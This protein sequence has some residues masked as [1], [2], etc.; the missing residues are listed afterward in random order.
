MHPLLETTRRTAVR[1]ERVLPESA[2]YDFNKGIWVGPNGP[3]CNDP[4]NI[5][6]TKKEDIEVGEDQKGQ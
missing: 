4:E 5:P 6:A 2:V 3:L 1:P